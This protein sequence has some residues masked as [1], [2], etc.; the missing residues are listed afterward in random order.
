MLSTIVL[1]PLRTHA[2]YRYCTFCALCHLRL[3]IRITVKQMF[4]YFSERE[5]GSKRQ[6][7][8][9]QKTNVL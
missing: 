3:F 4:F 5:S 6:S 7:E 8:R 9:A 2:P 1:L